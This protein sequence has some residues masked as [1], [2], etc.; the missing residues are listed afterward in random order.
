MPGGDVPVDETVV[1]C[2]PEPLAAVIVETFPRVAVSG[3][4]A[5]VGN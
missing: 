1:S 4:S 5:M 2:E 3:V